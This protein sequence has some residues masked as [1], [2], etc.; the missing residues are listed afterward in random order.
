MC[1]IC[2]NSFHDTVFGAFFL[3][4]LSICVTPVESSQAHIKSYLMAIER[5]K[6]GD[7]C[8]PQAVHISFSEFPS[9]PQFIHPEMPP[10]G[11]QPGHWEA[12]PPRAQ[13]FLLDQNGT[14]VQ[15][16]GVTLTAELP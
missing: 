14:V 15:W 6:L 5:I 2:V 7:G 1:P 10:S 11:H 9:Q 3:F 8:K 13:C 12:F 16:A 4:V